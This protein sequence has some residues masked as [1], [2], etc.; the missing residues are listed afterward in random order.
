MFRVLCCQTT[1][2][3]NAGRSVPSSAESTVPK[4]HRIV[5]AGYKPLRSSVKDS[6]S[7]GGGLTITQDA[8]SMH[9]IAPISLVFREWHGALLGTEIR[10][11]SS[12]ATTH[13]LYRVPTLNM[14]LK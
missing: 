11:Q 1:S 12:Y 3:H 10:L 14:R 6:V 4:V 13:P 9:S 7:P 8:G 2:D 5:L